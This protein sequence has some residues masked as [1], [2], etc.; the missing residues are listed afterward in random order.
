MSSGDE[1]I[2]Q[3][4]RSD[5]PDPGGPKTTSPRDTDDS[6]SRLANDT[7]VRN[8]LG[9][10][11]TLWLAIAM[12][13]LASCCIVFAL[14]TGVHFLSNIEAAAAKADEKE[15]SAFIASEVAKAM[16]TANPE[17]YKTDSAAV[18]EK[19]KFFSRADAVQLMA[20]LIPATFS[21]ALGLIILVT[22][23]RFISGF[24]L[25]DRKDPPKDSDYGAIATLVQEIVAAVKA[26]RGK[27]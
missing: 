25:S 4:D 23:T 22:L 26:M 1:T 9:R 24:V 14:Y 3:I 7:I 27:D 15:R 6:L 12:G 21:S 19:V 18:P 20:P 11:L 2:A 10:T 13:V 5:D 8:R 16:R 17:A